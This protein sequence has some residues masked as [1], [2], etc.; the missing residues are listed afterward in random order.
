[1]D[2]PGWITSFPRFWSI[3]TGIFRDQ[4]RLGALCRQNRSEHRRATDEATPRFLKRLISS[5][6]HPPG[7][8]VSG[9]ETAEHTTDPMPNQSG[10]LY[11]GSLFVFGFGD[12]AA[13]ET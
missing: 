7:V 4:I 9:Q 3:C 12:L 13:G 5:I 8:A 1:M 11:R 6:A 2:G 10:Q